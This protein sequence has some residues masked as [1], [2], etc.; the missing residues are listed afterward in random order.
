MKLLLKL[1]LYLSGLLLVVVFAAGLWLANLDPNEHKDWVSNKVYEDTGRTLN[2]DGDISLT[3]YPWLGLEAA[4]V[5]FSNAA[6]FGSEPFFHADYLKFRIKLMPLL[7]EKYEIDTGSIHG[8]VINLARNKD[9][10][11]NWDDLV[12]EQAEQDSSGFAL[13]AIVLG[14]LD[15]KDA[16][17]SW[18]D[19]T[20]DTRYSLSELNV[21]TGELV[22]G[23]PIDVALSVNMQA[24]KPAVSGTVRLNNT[25]TYD[26]DKGRYDI[27]P[28][29][30]TGK[31]NS[32][33]IPGG[34][35]EFS[36]ASKIAMNLQDDLAD[37]SELELD[38]LGVQMA[39][40]INISQLQSPTP[41][42]KAVLDVK[43]EDLARLFKVAEVE[44]LASQL[45]R[46]AD[47]S[48]SL[49]TSID[50]DMQRGDVDI[51]RL[52][53]NLLGAQL[54]GDIKARNIQ[55][56]TPGIKSTLQASG[57]DLPA[58]LQV[59]GQLSADGAVLAQYG[60]QLS[61]LKNKSFSVNV[62]FDADM[63]SGDIDVPVLSIQALG[64]D[65]DGNLKAN[66]M[67]SDAG[68]VSGKLSVNAK[69]LPAL[70]T[71][72]DQKDL[73]QSLQ[74]INFE[75]VVNGTRENLSLQPMALDAVFS[76]QQISTAP[77]T[78]ALRADTNIN[79]ESD[80][81]A[82][83]NFNVK[84]LGLNVSGNIQADNIS[85][86]PEYAGQINIAQFNLRKLLKQLN[87]DVPQT[88]DKKVLQ[89]LALNTSFSG[90][91]KAL[92]IR[93]LALVLDQTKLN[94]KFS[95]TNFEAPAYRFGI[96]IDQINIDRYMSPQAKGKANKPVTP[97]TA[98]GAAAQLPVEL[99]RKLDVQGDVNIGSLIVSNARLSKVK[100]SLNGKDGKIK[101][102]PVSA[103]L[104]QG[105]YSGNINLDA[106][107]KLPRLTFN[108]KLAGIQVEPLLQDVTGE[109]KVRGQGDFSA[110]LIAVGKNS[111]TM[112][113]TLNGQMS[114]HFRDGAI[115]GF[116]LGKIMRQGKSL[117][118]TFTLNVSEKEETDL[119]D[120]T[121]N[122]VAKNGVITLNDL[123]GN[124]PGLRLSGEGILADLGRNTLD[125]NVTA[126]IVATSTGQG[127]KQ[128]QEGKLEGIPLDCRFRGSLDNPKR[129]CD[130][131]KLVAAFAQQLIKGLI[132]LPKKAIP[133]TNATD[134]QTT[135]ADDDPAKQLQQGLDALKGIFGK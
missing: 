75:T 48:F 35:T 15:I 106:T 105:K 79:L 78:L 50:M 120:I 77:V 89:K 62:D 103:N 88:A 45:M 42:V 32:A 133:G 65:I 101:M 109:A 100:L 98:A 90:S 55:S 104:Y 115:K 130:A 96:N 58:L 17:L 74:S 43:G 41:S 108:S 12:K 37:I 128:L 135:T 81:L 39:G 53:A 8:A 14:G 63:K 84:G 46:L 61:S 70:L 121:G 94:G 111:D 125:Y 26:L 25:I 102:D 82:L 95:L 44:P 69:Q 124:S 113:K 29:K 24:N 31:I 129:K 67:D 38:I 54:K 4:D 11:N 112:K 86:S 49:N 127:G 3:F 76:G 80:K 93:E 18:D 71:A 13:T 51:S 132:G 33:N 28:L 126:S 116:N 60:Q 27:A 66:D 34:V 9:G 40:E 16:K 19:Q 64:A 7:Q 99:L 91:D 6:G 122:P 110:A 117:K 47:R 36:M 68:S 118:D 2:L 5:T 119:S 30:L 59:A 20:T 1:I 131:S 73:A 22:Y 97:E 52:S 72:I 92:N 134:G 85:N 56:V 21:S 123:K 10:V 87:Q 23:E 107:R 114:F 83:N 57:P